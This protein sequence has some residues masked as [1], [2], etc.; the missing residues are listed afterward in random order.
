ME[1]K[2]CCPSLREHKQ[3]LA[4]R[5][6]RTS[7]G[8]IDTPMIRIFNSVTIVSLIAGLTLI[9]CNKPTVKNE[10]PSNAG[11]PVKNEAGN[12]DAESSA[13]AKVV[14]DACIA[15]YKSLKSYDDVGVLTVRIPVSGSPD[16]KLISEP[17]RIAFDAPN[18]LAIQAMDL[19]AMWSSSTWEAVVGKDAFKPFGTQRL[20]RP[21]P[22]GI[23]LTWLIVDNLGATLNAPFT[24]SPIQLQLL[25]DE[26]PLAYLLESD[27]R[28]SLLK[29][30]VFDSRKCERV[31]VI[32]KEMKWVFWIDQEN[33]LLRKYEMPV[34]GI[35]FLV[36]GLPA[37]FDP[38]K[39]ELAIE[40]VGAKANS[41]V[42]WSVWQIPKNPDEIP[43][44]RL[45]DAPPRNTPPL[46]GKELKPFDLK[47]VDGKVILDSAQRAKLI[48]VL[49][50][51]TN[52]ELGEKFV[53]VLI[54]LQREFDK[55]LLSQAEIVL[56]SQAKTLDIQESL[57]RWN[58]NLPLA[59]DTENLTRNVFSIS[60]QPAVVILDKLVRV[61]HF[62][63]FG[64]LN[65]IPD[66]VEELQRGVDL[67]SRR[68]QNAIHD[69]ARFN[70]RLHRVL[71]EKSQ[72]EKLVPIESF[73]FTFHESKEAW[74][75]SFS[76][77]IIAASGEH[78][79]PQAGISNDAVEFFA[80]DAKRQRI[81]TVLDEL[82]HVYSVDNTGVKNWIANIP[83]DQADQAKRIHVLPDPWTHRWIAIVP[84][85]LP[86]Y[87]LI[88]PSASSEIDP[89]D[90][91]QYDLDPNES[92]VAFAW[93]VKDS[94]PSLAIAT[95][96]SKLR[97]LDPVEQKRFSADTGA[98]ASIVPSIDD[99]GE[100]LGWNAIK[101][102]GE[103]LE[104]ED[105]RSRASAAS[106]EPSTPQAKKLTFSPEPCEWAWGRN[107]NQGLLLGM[108]QLPSGETGTILQSRFFEPKLRHPLSARPEQCKIHSAATLSDGS[109]YWLS[110]APNRVLH[111]QTADGLVADQM[112]LGKRIISAGLFPD[113]KRMRVV[114]AVDTEVNCWAIEIPIDNNA[115]GA[116]KVPAASGPEEAIS[117]SEKP[118]A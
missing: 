72:T 107:R 25:F 12:G 17:M 52:D 30:E 113:R 66:I 45:I 8:H 21:L 84:E 3:D 69:E 115:S 73:P 86:R 80:A 55:R 109:L 93:T 47:G 112:S 27:S 38:S 36:P 79:P 40:L 74:H 28:I 65:L 110:T 32:S 39:A 1:T 43:V 99:R 53:K 10:S 35:G 76:D 15:K 96:L 95:S 83:I 9:G 105:L 41:S 71:V 46:I 85:G 67:A 18:K 104:I 97:V 82:G 101:S 20:V 60:R 57:K 102:D 81:M 31:Q 106:E 48:T 51:V 4:N 87:W 6:T 22:D 42:D 24:G 62:D 88:D 114:L 49:C 13:S 56:V 59:I 44:R 2:K 100:V 116:A 58:C 98:I 68:L 78:F 33:Q 29:P 117:P 14:L 16:P 54:D 64:Y 94:V 19:Q 92:P 7:L 89:V 77:T 108:A 63:E 11:S 75:V 70:S 37:D 118:G 34:Q 103:I 90:A 26:K 111:L 61:Q 91:T 50:W 5:K 23:D